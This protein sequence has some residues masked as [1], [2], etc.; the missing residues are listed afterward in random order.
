MDRLEHKTIEISRPITVKV[1][2]PWP[3]YR[4]ICGEIERIRDPLA[5]PECLAMET[6]EWIESRSIR[7]ISTA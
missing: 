6:G 7:D 4:L 5:V 1:N 2:R 3:R